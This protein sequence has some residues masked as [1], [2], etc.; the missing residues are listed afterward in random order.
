MAVAGEAGGA[1]FAVVGQNFPIRENGDDVSEGFLWR[2]AVEE[3]D[4]TG[5]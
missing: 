2:K 5:F 1:A 4:K 3:T